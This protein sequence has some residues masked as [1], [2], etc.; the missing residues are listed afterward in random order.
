MKIVLIED[1]DMLRKSLAFF[2]NSKNFEVIE[3]DNGIDA[4]EY[5]Q[6]E[7]NTID[8]II[9]DLNLPFAGGKQVIHACKQIPDNKTQ[10]IVLTSSSVENTELEV[11][12]LGADEFVA[13]P[14]SPSVLL[15]RIEKLTSA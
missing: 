9:T 4:I 1:E 6:N 13:K 14:F 7:H 5:I 2:L 11:F 3:F 8:V 10:I 15:K 12:N